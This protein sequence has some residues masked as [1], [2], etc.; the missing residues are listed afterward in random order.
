MLLFGE[1]ITA[2]QALQYGLINKV[3]KPEQLDEEIN[4]YISKVG[5]LSGE[6][7][8]LG[9]KVFNEQSSLNL[10]DAYCVAE[11]GMS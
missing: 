10:E 11:K 1:S 6:V 3:V 7:I 4:N 5:K 9:K 8:A 2:G